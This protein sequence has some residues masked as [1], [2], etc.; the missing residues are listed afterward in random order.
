MGASPQ[1]IDP[2]E[3][4]TDYAPTESRAAVLAT[5][6]GATAGGTA[7]S[8]ASSARSARGRA[9]SITQERPPIE[10]APGELPPG[11]DAGLLLHDVLEV[12]DLAHARAHRDLAS[13]AA[14]PTVTA[15]LADEARAR[16]IAPVY[17]P[18]ATKLV[19]DTLVKPLRLV[20]G[21]TLPALVD[22]PLLARE[23]EFAYPLPGTQPG[24]VRGFID[25]LVAWDDELWVLDYK[26]DLLVGDDLAAEARTR[27]TEQY[28]IQARLYAIAADRMR[29]HRRLGGLL[30]QFL[31]HDLVVA[32]RA[33]DEAIAAWTDW[34]ARLPIGELEPRGRA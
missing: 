20:D 29:G 13:W 8:S 15:Q 18:H 6:A 23:T 7:T 24:L 1:E 27:V 11:A 32:I 22:A 4:D 21:S 34:L 14:D 2:A 26:S 17:L 10:L 12:A 5:G 31:R 33:D 28:T 16:G 30:Y 25:A 3:F 19:H 9:K